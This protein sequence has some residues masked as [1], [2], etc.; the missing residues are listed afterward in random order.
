MMGGNGSRFNPKS[1]ATRAE[2]SAMLYRYIK[3]TLDPATAQGWAINDAGQYLYYEDGR[4]LTGWQTVN[5]IKYLFNTDGTLK[6]GWV[7]DGG[8]WRYYS[9]NTMLVGF[10]DIDVNGSNKRYYF[11]KDGIMAARKWLHVDGQWY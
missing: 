8:N 5:G 4:S 2:V 9:G 1:V 11:T 10:G 3:L 7:Q 6:T